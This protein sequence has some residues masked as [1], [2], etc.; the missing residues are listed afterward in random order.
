CR[1]QVGT[2]PPHPASPSPRRKCREHP[3]CA[4]VLLLEGSAC[5]V[6]PPEGTR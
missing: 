2:A 3:V 5:A 1:H 4:D 6:R